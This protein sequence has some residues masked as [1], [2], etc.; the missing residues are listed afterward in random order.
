KLIEGPEKV[1]TR[2]ASSML[3]NPLAEDNVAILGGS[4]D[5]SKSNKTTLEKFPD[6][7]AENHFRG[8][9]IKFGVREFALGTIGNALALN[10][11]RRSISTLFVFSDYIR[12]AIRLSALMSLRY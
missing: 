12:P 1:S 11:L 6:F 2:F 10:H 9:N 3:V 7:N 4:A 5:L 8:R